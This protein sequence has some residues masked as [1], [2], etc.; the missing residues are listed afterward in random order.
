MCRRETPRFP[1]NPPTG[2]VRRSGKA[3]Q[4]YSKLM[5]PKPPKNSEPDA[6]GGSFVCANSEAPGKREARIG[7]RHRVWIWGRMCAPSKFVGE[8]SRALLGRRWG[9]IPGRVPS[10]PPRTPRGRDRGSQNGPPTLSPIIYRRPHGSRFD[11][12]RR[13]VRLVK[14]AWAW[15]SPGE[16]RWGMIP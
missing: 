1:T 11:S 5:R 15:M 13:V 6:Q 14:I 8:M 12:P 4:R 10:P 2:R 16:L 7:I 3:R 9:R